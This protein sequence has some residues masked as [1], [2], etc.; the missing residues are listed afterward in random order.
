MGYRDGYGGLNM[1]KAARDIVKAA[2]QLPENERVQVVEHLLASLEPESDE[3]VDSAWA[4]EIER[5]SRQI[6]EGT[7][8]LIPWEE[9]RSQARKRARAKK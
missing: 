7:V 3:D 9:V 2:V 8:S 5:R 6:K 1:T 4:A